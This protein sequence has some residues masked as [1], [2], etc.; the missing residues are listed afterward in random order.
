MPNQYLSGCWWYHDLR[1]LNQ[2][3]AG[4]A[5]NSTH[6][7]RRK[8]VPCVFGMDLTGASEW[9]GGDPVFGIIVEKR[10]IAPVLCLPAKT[11]SDD[12]RKLT[13]LGKVMQN[14][15]MSKC[16]LKDQYLAYEMW[17]WKANAF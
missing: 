11:K 5:V 15:V 12:A 4:F 2:K 6:P 8:L 13:Q 7:E 10:S 16:K 9:T 17:L 14:V 1:F 3:A